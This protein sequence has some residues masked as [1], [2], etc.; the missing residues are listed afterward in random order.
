MRRIIPV[1]IVC[2]ILI[3]LPASVSAQRIGF[4]DLKQV[5]AESNPGK[6]GSAEL[7][8]SFESKQAAKQK[9]EADLEKEKEKL[10]QQQTAGIL[11]ESAL[12]EMEHEYTRK[13]RAYEKFVAEINQELTKEQQEFMRKMYVEISE[14]VKRVAE[15]DGYSLILDVNNPFVLYHSKS[16][17]NITGRIIA[18]YNKGSKNK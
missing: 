6:K 1:F 16:G 7:K 9:M 12:K 15:K 10:K 18:E 4:I 2:A 17:P 8:K 5:I 11:K 3:A 13:F 14:V